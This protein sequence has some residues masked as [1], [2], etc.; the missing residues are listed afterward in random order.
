MT[1]DIILG[2]IKHGD[3]SDLFSK[4][5]KLL[6]LYRNCKFRKLR[7]HSSPTKKQK[8]RSNFQAITK[9]IYISIQFLSFAFFTAV[10]RLLWQLPGLHKSSDSY[11][12][13]S[14]NSICQST[15]HSIKN[16]IGTPNSILDHLSVVRKTFEQLYL[17]GLLA[18]IQTS[19]SLLL[20][21][22]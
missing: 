5:E 15:K 7:S 13:F 18:K 1:F 2:N 8:E 14:E 6:E 10:C 3:C 22:K 21:L 19:L 12:Y 4:C 11:N 16:V 20:A 17:N 9:I